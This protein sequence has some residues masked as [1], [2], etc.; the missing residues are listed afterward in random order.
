MHVLVNIHVHIYLEYKTQLSG[1]SLPL[2]LDSMTLF[3][4]S[5]HTLMLTVYQHFHL[6]TQLKIIYIS[7]RIVYQSAMFVSMFTCCDMCLQDV[8]RVLHSINTLYKT[9]NYGTQLAIFDQS[10]GSN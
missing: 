6:Y 9:F 7:A 2:C 1:C 4:L 8:Q 3:T 5:Q 10:V